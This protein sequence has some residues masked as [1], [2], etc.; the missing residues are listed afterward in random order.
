MSGKVWRSELVVCFGGKCIARTYDHT[1]SSATLGVDEKQGRDRED[2]LNSTIAERCV[3]GLVR[4]IT[5]LREDCRAVE[6]DD[7][8]TAHLL[9]NHDCRSTV[10]C[11]PNAGNGEA[12]AEAGKVTCTTS[13]S[14][15]GLVDDIRVVVVSGGDNGVLSK[16]GH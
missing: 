12:V 2:D 14:E 7:V 10:V 13:H 5:G 8:D 6:G 3:Q 9:S 16:F 4:R 11:A 1:K 15:L